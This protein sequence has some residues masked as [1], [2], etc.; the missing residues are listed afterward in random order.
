[1][2][3]TPSRPSGGGTAARPAPTRR[4]VLRGGAVLTLALAGGTT[5][6]ACSTSPSEPELTAGALVPLARAADL[7]RS[8]AEQLAPR[9]TAYTAALR[10]VAAERGEHHRALVDE[11]NRLHAPAAA[12]ATAAAAEP[13]TELTMD[14]LRNGLSTAAR[15]N[16]DAAVAAHGFVAGL[17][18]SISASCTALGEVQLA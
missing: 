11:I 1:M 6:T 4:S 9:E 15:Q 3:P 18:A 2:N 10:Q 14:D 13:S 12:D 17:L 8:Q 16:A 5:A 7:Q